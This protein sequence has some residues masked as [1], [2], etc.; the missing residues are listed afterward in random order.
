MSLPAPFEEPSKVVIQRANLKPIDP[1]DKPNWWRS[2]VDDL[3][4]FIGMKPLYLSERWAEAKVGALEVKVESEKVDNEVKLIRA[5]MDYEEV[6]AEVREKDRESAARAEKEKA[7]AEY[8]GAQ[9]RHH[10]ALAR[11][12]E[13]ASR[14]KQ[15]SPDEARAWLEETQRKIEL[16]HGGC[17]EYKLPD[18]PPPAEPEPPKAPGPG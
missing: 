14:A 13:K 3:R 17:V 4:A 5:K 11:L 2:F 8:I 16:N 7:V 12:L 9:T 15:M 6:M 1:D 10:T 18:L